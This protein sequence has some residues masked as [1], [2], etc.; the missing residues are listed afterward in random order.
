MKNNYIIGAGP[1]GL[2]A[3][4]YMKDYK[5]IDKSPLGQLK[6]PF[7]PGPRLLQNTTNMSELID[8]IFGGDTRVEIAKI[9]YMENG[10]PEDKPYEGFK[11]K[12]VEKTRGTKSIESSHL[13][14]GKNEIEHIEIGMLTEE[15][16]AAVF[17]RLLEII[18]SRG[19][20]IE[21][22]IENIDIN[23]KTITFA[24]EGEDIG[25]TVFYDKVISTI[26]LNI[27][28]KLAPDMDIDLSEFKTKTKCFYKT[29]YDW[30]VDLQGYNYIYSA[31]SEWTRKTYFDSYIV[32]ESVEP[33][34]SKVIEDNIVQMKFENMPIQIVESKN[35]DSINEIKM[36]G[37][38][39]QWNH[40]V[41]A[42]EVLDRVKLWIS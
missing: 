38:F 25:L 10:F 17:N 26:N 23:N 8:E 35:I 7:I 21:K 34:D 24:G 20:L 14:E 19:Q 39:A 13:S 41:K 12:Y 15:S 37:R 28:S 29:S 2:I 3:A 31:D 11:T 5:V 9:G 42:N 32:Y 4:Y 27:L 33:I 18:K 36:L 22:H 30:M 40:K 6:A 1:A 16:Y